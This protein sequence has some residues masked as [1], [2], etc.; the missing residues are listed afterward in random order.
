MTACGRFPPRALQHH[1]VLPKG[2]TEREKP[3]PFPVIRRRRLQWP[4]FDTCRI[5][6]Q[7]QV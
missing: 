1:G 4:L 3:Q 5:K 6:G 7:K 2:P